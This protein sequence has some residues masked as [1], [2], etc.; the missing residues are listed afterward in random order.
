MNGT[1]TLNAHG[2]FNIMVIF[3]IC[4][5]GLGILLCFCCGICYLS[6]FLYSRVSRTASFEDIAV[7]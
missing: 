5:G 3:I 2:S 4:L 6:G 1:V 7:R